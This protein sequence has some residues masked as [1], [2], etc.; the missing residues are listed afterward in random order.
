MTW[1]FFA[2]PICILAVGLLITRS[3]RQVL[4]PVRKAMGAETLLVRVPVGVK[5]L[6]PLGWNTKTIAGMDISISP[7]WIRIGMT[8][9]LLGS[10]VGT[11]WYL[12]AHSLSIRLSEEPS[13]LQ[14]RQWIVIQG[15]DPNLD[16][17]EVA[18]YPLR[19]FDGDQL[20]NALL[21]ASARA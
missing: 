4:G 3:R 11:E 18:I 10:V 15:L 14:R 8:S 17:L 19:D 21:N 12:K 9:Q 7:S 16:P 1:L 13:S 5:H 20:W 2:G 6:G